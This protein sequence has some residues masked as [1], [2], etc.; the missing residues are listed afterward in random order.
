MAPLSTW[1]TELMIVLP[2]ATVTAPSVMSMQPV[3]AELEFVM[4]L[5]SLISKL[6][7]ELATT[8]A[9]AA[10]PAVDSTILLPCKVTQ[11]AVTYTAPAI[12]P[13]AEWTIELSSA[14]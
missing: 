8:I 5:L 11:P 9:P 14:N 2:F 6:A 1:A 7:R 13:A 12:L 4:I 10:S 3:L